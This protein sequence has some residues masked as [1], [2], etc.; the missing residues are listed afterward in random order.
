M[1]VDDQLTVADYRNQWLENTRHSVKNVTSEHYSRAVRLHILARLGKFKLVKLRPHH[2]QAVYDEKRR[3]KA[4]TTVQSV[5]NV[6]SSALKQAVRWQLIPTNPADATKRPKQVAEEIKPLTADEAK[7]L[8]V[9]AE[10]DPHEALYILALTTGAHIGELL[11]LRWADLDLGAGILR[12]ERTRSAAK[13][14]P[15]FTSPKGGRSRTVYLTPAAESLKRHR[16]RQNAERLAALLWEDVDLIFP[17]RTGG[18]MH[19]STVTDDRFKPLLDRAGLPR[20]TRFHDLRHTCATVLLS[21]GVD[22]VSVQRLLGHAS[23]SMTLNVY[24]HMLPGAGEATAAAMEA[25]LG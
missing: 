11:A 21:R 2:I 1:V 3:T 13:E 23:A 7:A 14:G 19:P 20:S 5:H 25:A 8:L 16:T 24:G 22:V 6:L 4:P 15:R 10:G 12:I 9:A 17:N 18:V